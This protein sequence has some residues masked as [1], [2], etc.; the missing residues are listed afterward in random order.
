MEKLFPD[1]EVMLNTRPAKITQEQEDKIC[2]E[3]AT[4]IIKSGWSSDD[5]EDVAKDLSNICPDY[6]GFQAA[7]SLEDSSNEANYSI[8][9]EFV[10][11]LDYFN[12]S[13]EN[14][15]IKNIK[16]WVSVFDIKPKFNKGDNLFIE[17]SLNYHLP[18]D[19]TIF[20]IGINKEQAHYYLHKNRDSTSGQV[21]TFEEVESKC[22]IHTNEN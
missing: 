18:K 4:E 7:K 10:D 1:N 2:T 16:D 17:K 14:L 13:R 9:S 8:D 20:I 19:S 15:L 22:K 12:H 21:L 3:F 11:Y 5:I 6:N